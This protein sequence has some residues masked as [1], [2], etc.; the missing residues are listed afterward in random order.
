MIQVSRGLN[1]QLL[2]HELVWPEDMKEFDAPEYE[3]KPSLLTQAETILESLVS[4][5]DVDD[6]KKASR[7]R[8]A[9][10]L[11]EKLHM[12]VKKPSKKAA[13]VQDEDD[14]LEKMLEAALAAAS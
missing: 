1:N 11:A 8:I 9:G 12:P 7:A 14:K 5:F 6:Y 3:Y 13:P 10:L 4:D 2:F